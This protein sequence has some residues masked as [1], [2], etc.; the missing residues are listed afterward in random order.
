MFNNR[1]IESLHESYAGVAAVIHTWH[2]SRAMK[3]LENTSY[4][5]SICSIIGELKADTKGT[6]A[7]EVA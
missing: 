1:R 3:R 7:D 2:S 6:R 4:N 5:I